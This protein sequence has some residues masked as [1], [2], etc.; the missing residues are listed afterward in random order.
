MKASFIGWYFKHQAKGKTLAVIPGKAGDQA[1]IQVI[2]DSESFNIPFKLSEFKEID[3]ARKPKCSLHRLFSRFSAKKALRIGDNIFSSSG[4]RLC[5]E[6]ENFSLQGDLRFRNLTP[7]KG[8]IMGPFCFFPMECRHGIISM[9]HDVKGKVVLNGKKM[10]FKKG[11]GYIEMDSGY[12]F[13][14]G[15]TW[16]QCNDFKED[17]SIM[18]AVAK[19]PFGLRFRGCICVVWLNG[20]EYRLATYKGAKIVQCKHNYLE[21]KQGKYRLFVKTK[22]KKAQRLAAPRFGSMNRFI[23]ES[24]S[25]PAEFIFMHGDKVLFKGKSKI[26]SYEWM[27]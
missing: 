18:A 5:I 17:C 27:I 26:A 24:V 16:V 21:I 15:Y 12:S 4:I 20:K 11:K 25:C 3:R 10:K 19:I 2:T 22:Q 14:E 7:I 6:R 23:K 8:K 13:P 1:F 9:K